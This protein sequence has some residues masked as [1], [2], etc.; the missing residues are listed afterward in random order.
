AHE[1]SDKVRIC[2]LLTLLRILLLASHPLLY[3]LAQHSTT[4][5]NQFYVLWVGT[6]FFLLLKQ[7]IFLFSVGQYNCPGQ[8]TSSRPSESQLSLCS[9][10]WIRH[11]RKCYF[12]STM[13]GNWTLAQNVCSKHGATLTLVDSE[14][15]MMFLRQYV[16][17]AEH[18]IRVKNE[19]GHSQKRLNGKELNNWSNITESEN[20]S[21]LGSIDVG[22]TECDKNLHWICSK[23]SH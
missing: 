8:H 9:G 15:E 18:W 16:G 21:F 2:L 12:A 10:G 5:P 23:P 19:T 13:T 20:C 14:E 6:W 3:H 4:S 7:T 11:Q 17:R 1:Q 22:R